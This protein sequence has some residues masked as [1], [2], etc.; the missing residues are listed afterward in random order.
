MI[1]TT[2]T[3]G[4]PLSMCHMYAA[5][6]WPRLQS[7]LEKPH[8]LRVDFD[9]WEELSDGDEEEEEG[10]GEGE[11]KPLTREKLAEIKEKQVGYSL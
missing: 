11:K 10:E 1:N 9:H 8:W 7:T 5:Y 6:A 3:L 4:S 2:S